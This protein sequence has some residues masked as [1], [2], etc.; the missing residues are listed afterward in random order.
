MA[1]ATTKA[2]VT[3]RR[4]P[5]IRP[6]ATRL[7]QA[8]RIRRGQ[9]CERS[10]MSDAAG[11]LT[12]VTAGIGRARTVIERIRRSAYE[13]DSRPASLSSARGAARAIDPDPG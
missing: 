13:C 2:D 9:V 10:D 3:D 8:S 6:A 4:G 12:S 7:L 1:G 5:P 11:S